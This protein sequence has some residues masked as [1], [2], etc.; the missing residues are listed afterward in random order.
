MYAYGVVILPPPDLYREL[1][2]LRKGNPL[3]R[4][5]VPP[6]HITVKSPFLFR[7]TGARVVEQLE[8]LCEEWEPFEIQLGG[9]GIFQ[10]SILYVQVEKSEDLEALHLDIVDALD[11]FVETLSDRFDG[12]QYT[13]HLTLANRLEPEELAEL[14]R[15]LAGV[16]LRRR[17][18]VDQIH[19]LRGRGR[20]DIT[21][22]FRLGPQ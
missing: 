12:D 16:R 17:F 10:D 19:L 7:Q 2:K 4:S 22:S 18:V 1:M 14:R 3:F 13:P 11:G 15:Q 21:H 8:A 6:P 20:W 5:V 9:L